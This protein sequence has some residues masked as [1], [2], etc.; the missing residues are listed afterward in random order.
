MTVAQALRSTVKQ[1]V[2]ATV[3]SYLLR[4]PTGIDRTTWDRQYAAGEWAFLDGLAE[5]PRY[6]VVAG[7]CRTVSP[8]ASVLDL[9]CG[10]GVLRAWLGGDGDRRYLGIDVSEVAVRKARE[11]ASGSARFEA[12]DV[13]TF[14]PDAGE[15]FDVVVLNEVLYYVADPG[16]LVRRCSGFLAPGGMIVLS[17]FR[18]SEALATW[19]QCSGLLHVVD[20]IRLRRDRGPEWHVRF[21]RPRQVG[22]RPA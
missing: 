7:Y 10:T 15:R 19:R 1:M 4:R 2:P 9:G 18:S 22:A 11:A 21:C 8:S 14:Q 20:G 3:G 5:M 16:A 17:M 12:A 13:A 6:G